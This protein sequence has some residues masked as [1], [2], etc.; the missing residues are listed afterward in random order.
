MPSIKQEIAK[1]VFWIAI[2]RYSGI[3]ISLGITAILARNVSPTA[4]GTMAVATVITAFL[5]I[6]IDMGFGTAI[7]Q[8]KDLTT[9]QINSIF[10]VGATIGAILAIGMFF[11]APLIANYYSDP[12]LT[13]VC[14]CL[15]IP[16]TFGALN[17]V[18]NGLM[19]K[20]KR[21]RTV[22]LRTLSFQVLC[23]IVAVIGALHGWGIYALIVTPVIT[24]VGVFIVNFIN[25]PQKFTIDI[26]F[27]AIC[28]VWSYSSFQFLFNFVNYFSRNLDKLIIG[29]YFSMAQLG[30][31]DKS[32]RL[33][34]LPLQNITFVIAPVLHPILS[35]LQDDKKQLGEKNRT[36]VKLLSYISFP[37]G[38]LLYFSANDIINIIFGPDWGP[39]IPVFRILAL[40]LPLQIILSTSGSFF[41][42][43]GKT[44]HMFFVGL[45]STLTTVIGF[46]IAVHYYHTL[47]SMAWAWNITLM[48]NFIS[49]YA[50]MNKITFRASLRRFLADFIPQIINTAITIPI[51]YYLIS[52]IQIS[53]NL[54]S[55]IY[56]TLVVAI[57]TVIIAYTTR[58]YN[59]FKLI[60]NTISRLR[61]KS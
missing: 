46:L 60:S 18:P 17:I 2:A 35:S 57:P 48:I 32:Y 9:R 59:V 20:A 51:A 6:F 33:M 61:H 30:Y 8:F 43:A 50:V 44:N 7:V 38:I 37:L 11:T 12:T 25:Y 34:Q 10:M 21:F 36:L 3:F 41:Q 54:F 28:R 40:S 14:R 49:S 53:N 45:T 42:A 55:L 47:V 58:Q 1:G 5:D 52:H 56:K 16:I 26:D 27:G 19:M 13:I 39:A 4:F 31:Y 24:S 29:R 23:G 15:C 22:A